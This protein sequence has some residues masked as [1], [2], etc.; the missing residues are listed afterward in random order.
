LCFDGDKAGVRAAF[1]SVER[2]LPLIKPGQ[3]L[4]FALLPEGKDPDD[5]IREHGPSAMQDVLDRAI[6]LVDMVWRREVSAEPLD[7]PEEGVR[8]QYKTA[9]LAKFDAEY[10]RPKWQP[11]GKSTKWKPKPKLSPTQILGG[12]PAALKEKRE[13]RILGAILEWPELME[14]VD[15]T[16]FGLNFQTSPYPQLQKSLLSYWE[17]TISVDKRAL[18]AHIEADGLA[19]T[20]NA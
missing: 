14:S 8:D 1:R 12:Q 4:R 9:L 19:K 16:L 11:S 2:A 10:G 18:H 20:L 17:H 6:P 13:R 3:T 7:T 15:Q 5:L